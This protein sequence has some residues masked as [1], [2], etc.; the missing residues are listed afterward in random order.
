MYYFFSHLIVVATVYVCMLLLPIPCFDLRVFDSCCMHAVL[1][2]WVVV[3]LFIPS[4]WLAASCCALL[5]LD[6]LLIDWLVD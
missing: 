1:L 3:L 6:Y 4:S 2:C 5:C